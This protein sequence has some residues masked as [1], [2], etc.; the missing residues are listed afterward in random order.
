MEVEWLILADAAQVVG[1]KL[2]LMGGGWDKLLINTTLPVQQ[3]IAVAVA[4]RV[5]WNETNR[6]AT[7]EIE[8]QTEDGQ[9]VA[10]VAGQLET[11]RPAGT[12]AGQPQRVQLAVNATLQIERMGTYVIIA[13][14]EGADERRTVFNVVPGPLWALSQQ[15]AA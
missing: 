5:P 15:G 11:S 1:E 3:P 2:F 10:K 7:A 13:R 8:F 4:F 12:P 14:V 6:P 9:V